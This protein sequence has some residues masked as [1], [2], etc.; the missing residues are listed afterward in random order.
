MKGQNIKFWCA[1]RK[2][3]R[4]TK[5]AEVVMMAETDMECQNA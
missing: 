3:Q 2:T 1:K 5:A 4:A